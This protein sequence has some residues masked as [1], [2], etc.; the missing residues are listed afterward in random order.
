MKREYLRPGETSGCVLTRATSQGLWAEAA[1][2]ETVKRIFYNLKKN[3]RA[4]P[5]IRYYAI[6]EL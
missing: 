1:E 2:A 5:R 4:H 6:C 3:V